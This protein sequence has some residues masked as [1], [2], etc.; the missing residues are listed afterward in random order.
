[1]EPVAV[2]SIGALLVLSQ[3]CHAQSDD[4]KAIVCE[5]TYGHHLQG[6]AGNQ[7]DTLYWSFTTTLVKT[8]MNGTVL[9]SVPVEN[10]HGDLCCVDG[11]VYVA[12]SNHFNRPGA[13]SK[14]YV[15]DATDLSLL[16]VKNV[17]EATFGAGGVEQH[18]GHFFIVGGLP[19]DHTQNYVYEYDADFKHIATHTIRSGYTRLGIQTVCFHDGHWWFGC[20]TVDGEKGLLKTDEAFSLLGIYNVSPAIGLVGWGKGRF[21]FAQHFG[22][23]W[24]AKAVWARPDD[25]LGLVSE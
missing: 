4:S 12:Y 15:Y 8:D 18:N 17:P 25:E 7:K 5:G 22:E 14:V 11:K 10:H 20:Y 16:G 13:D 24:Q 2:F 1:M 21:L 6:I 19:P 3:A 9:A 23:K